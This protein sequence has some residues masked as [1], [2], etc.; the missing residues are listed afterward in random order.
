MCE[1][2]VKDL[3]FYTAWWLAACKRKEKKRKEQ[4]FFEMY[5]TLT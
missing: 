5:F 3:G 2:K 4:S 1:A